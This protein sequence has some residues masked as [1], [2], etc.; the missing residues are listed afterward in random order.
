MKKNE[1]DYFD[2]QV[3]RYLRKQMNSEE[4]MKFKTELSADKEKMQR[5]RIVALMI[6]SMNIVGAERDR[7]IV[8]TI[9]S[10][11]EMQFR[12]VAGLNRSHTPILIKLV[13]YTVAACFVCLL[14]FTGY[15]YQDYRQTISLGKEAYPLYELDIYADGEFGK[16][17]GGA[18][19]ADAISNLQTLF[20]NVKEGKN[21]KQT[22][23][24]LEVLYAKALE[25]EEPYG[26]Y[27]DD[28]TWN[29]AI[30]YLKDGNRTKP[31]P[32]LRK[33][34]ERNRG[35]QDIVHPAQEL[36]RNIEEL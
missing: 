21:I 16:L 33:M 24:D 29:L 9:R 8:N 34:I 28:I 26:I 15:R 22:I 35:Y 5:A 18:V 10:M 12:K 19:E 32:L 27:I 11:D 25:K 4:M 7:R 13:K 20:S 14:A 1:Y 30:A 6:K 2:S 36:I 17:R 3:D 23:K 31:I